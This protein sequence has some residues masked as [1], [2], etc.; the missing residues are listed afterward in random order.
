[1]K[2]F[3][4]TFHQHNGI[5]SYLFYRFRIERQNPKIQ[6]EDDVEKVLIRFV[7]EE[8]INHNH[9]ED[10]FRTVQNNWSTFVK[11]CNSSLEKVKK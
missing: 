9:H 7:K 3:Q 6:T 4:S 11:W 8:K 5:S 1:M 2:K 10:I